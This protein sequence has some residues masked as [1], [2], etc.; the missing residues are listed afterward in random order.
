MMTTSQANH[1]TY[2]PDVDGLRALAVSAV[3]VNHFFSDLLPSG[4]L[5]VD[6][7]FVI[8]GFVI[9]SSLVGRPSQGLFDFILAFYTRR[10]KRIIPALVL[11]VLVTGLL[12]CLVDPRPEASLKTGIASLFGLSNLYLLRQS[13][14]YFSTSTAL[15]V[16]THTWSLGVEEQFYF[17]FPCLIQ[18]TGRGRWATEGRRNLLLATAA[19]SAVSLVAFV[20]L[21]RTDQPSAYFL[22]PTRLWELGVGCMLL[23]GLNHS[24]RL[25]RLCQQLPASAIAAGIVAVFFLPFRFAVPAT[26]ASVALTAALIAS[27]RQ[28]TSAYTLFTN[29][30]VVT[31]GLISYSL[32]LWHWPV[33]ALSRWTVGIHWWSVPFQVFVMLLLAGASYRYVEMPLR[34]A[35]WS[36]IRWRSV[37]Y[38]VSAS[39]VAAALLFVFV[40]E[41][42]LSRALYAGTVPHMAAEGT[43]S[44][45]D[46]YTL[47]AAHSSW[48]GLPCVL[49]DNAQVGKA[50]T[51]ENCTLGDFTQAT[52]RVLV[53][54][55]SF[56]AAFVQGFD[57][58]VISDGY[59]VTI[60]SCWGASPVAGMINRNP[61]VKAN[62]DYWAR[63]APDLI[64]R[65]RPGDWV[66]LVNDLAFLSPRI[67][68]SETAEDLRL[69]E[70]GLRTLSQKLSTKG[71]RLA[72]L[73]GNPFAREAYCQPVSAA[74]QWF[75]PFGAR[76]HQFSGRT[77]SMRRR[78]DVDKL[79]VGLQAA[80]ALRIVDLFD[81]FCPRERCTYN[82]KNGQILYRDEF[83]HPSVEGVRLSSPIIRRV[84]TSSA[85][86]E[87]W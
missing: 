3:I 87:R 78:N 66:F 42:R 21:Y 70:Q 69:F 45:L 23:V 17:V 64:N 72:I 39:A 60:T 33:L 12:I 59:A 25:V 6:I 1:H 74:E 43:Y 77:E 67:R 24:S 50:I 80:G 68:T 16:F 20:W 9:T 4:Y 30:R 81:V 79:L 34:R 29:R 51:I 13:T 35:Q 86:T 14:D 11:C 62:S 85:S 37:G 2:R 31:L 61:W 46:T 58:L 52:K 84:L 28:G 65:L 55:N 48:P 27:L 54:G 40:K 47:P 44:L 75:S 36:V 19:L 53:L 18:L 32:Y 38:G 15:N 49:S 63:V 41:P 76:C 82:A 57:D 73:H 7:F 5:G 71:L 22:M 8:S 26:I 83:S 56:S 10:V